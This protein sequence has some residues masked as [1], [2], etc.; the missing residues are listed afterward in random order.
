MA[1]AKLSLRRTVGVVAADGALP[2]KSLH[3][4]VDGGDAG[5]AARLQWVAG[6][7]KTMK[8]LQT[9]NQMVMYKT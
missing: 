2:K 9:V 4:W 3:E 5:C 7:D 1:I 6:M 8:V